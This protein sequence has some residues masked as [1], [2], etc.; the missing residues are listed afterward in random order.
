MDESNLQRKSK[1]FLNVS[2]N[3]TSKLL[4]YIS[5]KNFSINVYIRKLEFD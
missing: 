4:G 5:K 3:K 2:E 1:Y